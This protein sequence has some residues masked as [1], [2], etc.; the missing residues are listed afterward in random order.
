MLVSEEDKRSV[1]LALAGALLGSILSVFPVGNVLVLVVLFLLLYGIGIPQ[2][3]IRS[4]ILS[5]RWKKKPLKIGILND[6]GWDIENGTVVDS[7]DH[8]E[9]ITCSDVNPGDWKKT[10][11]K[12]A[13]DVELGVKI[14]SIK[15]SMNFDSYTAILNP[16]GGTYPELDLKNLSTLAKI[17][18]Y[19]K[20]GGLFINVADILSYWAHSHDLHRTLDITPSI[21]DATRG[22]YKPFELT[23]LMKTLGLRVIN[24]GTGVPPEPPTPAPQEQDLS[25]VLGPKVTAS[26]WSERLAIVE[27]NVESCI[28]TSKR[29]GNPYDFSA[30]FFV[31]YG[32][33]EFLFSLIWIVH[34]NVNKPNV[35]KLY[36][37]SQ[38]A[39]D[40]IRDAISKLAIDKLASKVTK[41]V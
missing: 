33:G 19:V 39:K 14:E 6:L 24:T 9:I 30:L 35:N 7:T 38:Q 27:S 15:V 2:K 37:N 26:I 29:A 41:T 36:H 18:G 21:Y 16:Y 17:A 4:C 11:E 32:E 5:H 31:K 3:I 12:S 20:E 13:K 34:P 25:P 10:L 40:A 23:P 22:N 1:A 28:P 8:K